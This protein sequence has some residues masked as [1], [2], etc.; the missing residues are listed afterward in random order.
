MKKW[1]GKKVYNSLFT[2]IELVTVIAIILILT[3]IAIPTY[4]VI[5]NN[6][7]KTKAIAEIQNFATVISAFQMDIGRLPR[8]LNELVI[9]PGSSKKWQGPYL[10]RKTIQKDP[11]QNTYIFQTP[12][13]N[14]GAGTYDII[15]YGSDG[16]LGGT[17]SGK[18]ITNWP[19]DDE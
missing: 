3:G 19:D 7:K 15:C 1:N 17:G 12:S 5:T 14:G 16:V 9:N 2:L 18:D 11:W 10:K 8:T 6:A 4:S 13:Q